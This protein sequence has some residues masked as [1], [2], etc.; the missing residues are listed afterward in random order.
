MIFELNSSELR[1]NSTLASSSAAF[2]CA[3]APFAES[4]WAIRT[5]INHKEQLPLGQIRAILELPL[6]NAS[7]DLRGYG[8]GLESVALA[9]L[10]EVNGHILGLRLDHT[11][12]RRRRHLG[13]SSLGIR[14]VTAQCC[15]LQDKQR[16][17]IQKPEL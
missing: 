12:Q 15:H 16:Q 1:A 14:P 2:A 10:V 13:T 3:R 9:D 6:R 5:R 7:A 4:S 8:N 11:H 17:D